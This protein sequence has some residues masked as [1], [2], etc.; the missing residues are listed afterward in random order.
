MNR[1]D[2]TNR[3]LDILEYI[4]AYVEE[5]HYP[6]SWRDIARHFSFASTNTVHSHLVLL[7]KKGAVTWEPKRFRTLRVIA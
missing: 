5:R 4:E 2:L 1:A 3:Q 6:P 7:Y